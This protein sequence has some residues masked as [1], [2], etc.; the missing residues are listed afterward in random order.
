MRR[1]TRINATGALVASASLAIL[2][3]RTASPAAP[4]VRTYTTDADFDQGAYINVEHS[5]SGSLELS[6]VTSPFGFV[7]I[8]KT[9][10]GTVVKIDAATA[11]VVGEY[12][13]SPRYGLP[14]RTAVDL[15]GNV[16]VENHWDGTVTHIGLVE[17]GQC[18]DRNGN[19]VI[20]TSA[21]LGD[22]LPWPNLNGGD[23]ERD[24]LAAQD[25]CVLHFTRI[26]D[27]YGTDQ[28]SV[29]ANNDLWVGTTR[30]AFVT[31]DG[32]SGEI[33]RVELGIGVG[34]Y[35]GLMAD[36][37][38]LW[39][40]G[41]SGTLR[42]D[43]GFELVAPQTDAYA[44]LPYSSSELCID[45]AGR[46]W[47]TYFYDGDIR[48]F[49]PDGK[50]AGQYAHGGANAHGCV[51]DKRDDVWVAHTS[52]EGARSVGHLDRSGALIDV[53]PVDSG[54]THVGVD[55]AGR[56]WAT[57]YFTNEV[58]RIDPAL[59]PTDPAYLTHIAVGGVSHS[60]GDITGSMLRGAPLSGTWAAVVDAGVTG[61]K[62]NKVVYN[63]EVF[64][65]GRLVVTAASSY[66][67]RSW[68]RPVIVDSGRSLPVANGRYLK[69]T[70]IFSRA[71]DGRSPILTDL[72]VRAMD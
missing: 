65:D 45:S 62:W 14:R 48:V 44:V 55:P 69:L 59:A 57:N 1:N 66:D 49:S 3:A 71:S 20:D 43:T 6:S 51:V 58:A 22:V 17:H 63:G 5:A 24:L 38:F 34:G 21:R 72:S 28:V 27:N 56:I 8:T 29:D 47:S 41:P 37:G 19:G 11:E 70:A 30:G 40:T 39:S 61:A 54:P 67:G 18:V 26:T 60:L 52:A 35:G 7:W 33:T 25:E 36:D 68:T 31:V 4:L 46:I 15:N 53:I 23:A 16:W 2:L 9:E 12:R 50:L 32:R 64:G 13:T 10:K 42:W